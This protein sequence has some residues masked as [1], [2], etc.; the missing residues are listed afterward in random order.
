MQAFRI[1]SGLPTRI[2]SGTSSV[3]SDEHLP[4]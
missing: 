2:R 4:K 1:K 3:S